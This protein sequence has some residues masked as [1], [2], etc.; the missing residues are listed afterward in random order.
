MGDAAFAIGRQTG[1]NIAIK[2]QVPLNRRAPAIRGQMDAAT[3][4][5][6]LASAS[7]VSVRR[8][9]PASFVL[10]Q[11]QQPRPV[12]R[13][14]VPTTSR[15]ATL[16]LPIAPPPVESQIVV[17]ASKRDTRLHRLQNQWSRVGGDV[18]RPLGVPGA[19]A[20]EA[21]S[22]GFSSTHLGAG[23]N[24]LFIRGIADS[25][26]SG[27]TQ[28][29]VGQYLGDTRT[30]YSGPD[31]DLKLVD[32]QSVEILAGPQGTLYGSG[33]LGGIVL[34]KPN[35]PVLGEV[36]GWTA[37]GGSSTSRGG[38]GHDA[39]AVLNAPL[40]RGAA[41]RLVGY[42]A[43]EGGYVDNEAT[44]RKDVND[45]FVRGGRA[46]LSTKLVPGWMLDLSGLVQDID[47]DDSQYA[48][49]SGSKLARSSLVEQPFSSEFGLA[50]IVIRKDEGEVR[51]RS[52]TAVTRQRVDEIFDAS[53]AGRI[54]ALQQSSRARAMSNETR[55]WR[56]MMDGYSWLAG[57]S[58]IVHSYGINRNSVEDGAQTSLG[59]T[60]NRVR[61]T[62]AY[63]EL[64]VELL[65][66]I[67]VTAGARFTVTQ[68]SGRGEHLTALA[69][70]RLA[71]EEARR[72]ERRLLP[73]ASIL[74][75]A[76]DDL[77]VYARYQQGFRPGGLSIAND[78]VRL[79]RNDRL[80]T[81]ELGL[82]HGRSGSDP[83]QIQASATF[84]RWSDIQADYL[85]ATGLPLTDNIGDGRVWTL[86][87]SGS[88]SIAPNLRVEGGIAWNNG[89]I[90]NPTEAFALL[91]RAASVDAPATSLKNRMSIPNIARVV[92]RVAADWRGSL[93]ANWQFHANAYGRYVGRSRLGVGPHLGREQ[94]EYFDTG[95]VLS[96]EHG[97]RNVSLS[98]TNL[99]NQVGD[100]FAFGAPIATGVDQITPLRPRSIRLGIQQAF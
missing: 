52:T 22:D 40:W 84:S 58:S 34:L 51:F 60:E 83:L 3:A 17:T 77:S 20:I 38:P 95:A 19:E 12:V 93:A 79:Y 33:A 23:R 61:E 30:G 46:I 59:G 81:A 43:R 11:R 13:K 69:A 98:I 8:V 70:M 15:R 66:L 4:L 54:R 1:V 68:I 29:P 47:G 45:V 80:A 24:K 86:T 92:A 31:P 94:G 21:R 2:G 56:P 71:S 35:Q 9:G 64:G 41:I 6:R 36:S 14:I 42:T 90:T 62:T 65:R 27:P 48:D 85:D 53:V 87:A 39:S 97:G 82:R 28:S 96:L 100:R 76:T 88:A 89:R 73:T 78:A 91:A 67:D 50:S 57:V 72:T 10:V 26:F 37:A 5:S 74:F 55:L 75:R 32:M 44:G 49:D 99:A 16:T 63:G 25:S 7:G 18:F